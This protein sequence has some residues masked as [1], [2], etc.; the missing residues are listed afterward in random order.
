MATTVCLG[1]GERTTNGSRCPRCSG[2]SRAHRGPSPYRDPRWRARV[3]RELARHRATFGARC[4][5][6]LRPELAE[7]KGTRLSLNHVT[8]LALG[9]DLMGPVEVMCVRCNS[10]QV[11][12]DM[13]HLASRGRGRSR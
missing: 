13:P 8:P 6:C 7:D 11:H 12:V 5:R 9:G 10:E 4:P 1:C 2:G 3:Q